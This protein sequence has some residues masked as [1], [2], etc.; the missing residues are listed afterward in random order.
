ME[1]DLDCI[2]SQIDAHILSDHAL[3]AN[4][5]TEV[6]TPLEVE[7]PSPTAVDILQHFALQ[8]GDAGVQ[9]ARA[10]SVP[11]NTARCTKWSLK[12][13]KHRSSHRQKQF[14]TNPFKCPVHPLIATKYQLDY[15]LS[16]FVVEA[17]RGDAEPY[18]PN[19]LYG[20]CCGL[21]RYVRETRPAIKFWKDDDFAGFRKT[22]DGEMKR[23]RSIGLG[24]KT[25]QA[26]PLSIQEE[27]QLWELGVL[28]DHL[29]Q[30]L[31]DTM[32]FLCGMHFALRS[33]EP[34]EFH[35]LNW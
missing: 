5:M 8:S 11:K 23:L 6:E 10:N 21:L 14:S 28:G 3:L 34:C 12:T 35:S 1:D 2:L 13:W 22:L 20:I 24:V 7:T 15:W 25:E 33:T 29:P 27:N 17:R 16:K 9:A 18:P 30:A 26:E 4:L 19:T 31:L 32:L